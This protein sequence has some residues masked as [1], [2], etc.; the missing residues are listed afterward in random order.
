MGNTVEL[1][2]HQQRVVDELAEL[3]AK[4]VALGKFLI[5]PFFRS[6]DPA[7]QDRLQ[8]Q[9]GYMSQY[10]LVLSERIEAF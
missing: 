3:E 7:E 5:A 9:H 6:L 10:S 2:P 4:R 8:R 1:A